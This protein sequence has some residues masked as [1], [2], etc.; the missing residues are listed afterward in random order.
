MHLTELMDTSPVVAVD[1]G[2]VVRHGKSRIL[3]ISA[4]KVCGWIAYEVHKFDG[5][6]I[7]LFHFYMVACNHINVYTRN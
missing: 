1:I 6:S 3:Y 2:K 5:N 4:V 7:I